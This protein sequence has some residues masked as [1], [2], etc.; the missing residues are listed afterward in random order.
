MRW[1]AGA[2]AAIAYTS[3]QEHPSAGQAAMNFVLHGALMYLFLLLVL[4]TTSNRVSQSVTNIDLVF[5]FV[6]GGIALQPVMEGDPAVSAAL[7]A[8][9][10]FAGTHLLLSFAKTHWAGVGRT[11]EGGPAV[12]YSN[13]AWDE[14]QLFAQR[15]QKPDVLAQMRAKGL[16]SL[17]E[18]KMAVL[19]PN[20]GIS[21]IPK[22]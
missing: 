21:I 17:D 1:R 18:I 19:E 13:G 2:S 20:G 14:W 4:R 22:M 16:R 12:L 6:L 8:L 5:V 7:V 11:I 3:T 15:I 10:T 9:C